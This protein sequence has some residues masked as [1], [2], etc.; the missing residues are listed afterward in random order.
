ME[1]AYGCSA[2]VGFLWNHGIEKGV[3]RY[4]DGLVGLSNGTL[5]AHLSSRTT[6][7]GTSGSSHSCRSLRRRRGPSLS[8]Y[9]GCTHQPRMGSRPRF[10]CHS[11]QKDLRPKRT[12]YGGGWGGLWFGHCCTEFPKRPS[13]AEDD[14]ERGQTSTDPSQRPLCSASSSPT[15]PSSRAS[16]T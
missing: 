6:P 3:G 5:R 11:F 16:T 4:T 12:G 1:G 13:A 14:P 10:F 8:R 9:R 7:A 15:T 2:T